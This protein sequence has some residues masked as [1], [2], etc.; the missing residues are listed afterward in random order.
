M[1]VKVECGVSWQCECGKWNNSER[2]SCWKCHK[3]KVPPPA[4]KTRKRKVDAK[5]KDV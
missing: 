2:T 5:S 3:P 1:A 4:R